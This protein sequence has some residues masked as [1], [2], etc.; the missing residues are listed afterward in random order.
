MNSDTKNL[1]LLNALSFCSKT[2]T[3][4]QF[5]SIDLDNQHYRCSGETDILDLTGPGIIQSF[6]YSDD[7]TRVMIF[8][9]GIVYDSNQ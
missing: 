9:N 7:T 8:M 2:M 3:D 4:E 6:I 5:F 1:L